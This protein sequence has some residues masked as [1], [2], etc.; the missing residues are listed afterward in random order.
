MNIRCLPFALLLLLL[1]AGC[2]SE[3]DRWRDA[4]EEGRRRR[5]EPVDGLIVRAGVERAVFREDDP[6]IVYLYVE[7]VSRKDIPVYTELETGVLIGLRILGRGPSE[8]FK[9]LSPMLELVRTKDNIT[10]VSHY[11]VLQP[12]Y[13]I[14]RPVVLPAN[15]IPPGEYSLTVAYLNTFRSCLAKPDFTADELR[16]LQEGAMKQGLWTGRAISNV[17]D[18]KVVKSKRR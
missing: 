13:Y 3:A 15:T 18:F 5:P 17:V 16:L 4:I 10:K 11:V 1:P 9:H 12:G 14:G 8:G 7:N 2:P 6:I